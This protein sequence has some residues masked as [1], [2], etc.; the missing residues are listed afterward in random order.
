MNRRWASSVGALVVVIAASAS[1]VGAST[2]GAHQAHSLFWGSATSPALDQ[3]YAALT[4]V[5]AVSADDVWA[6]GYQVL[7]SRV[8]TLVEHWDGTSWSVVPSPNPDGA[9]E[10]FLSGVDAVATDNVWAVGEFHY[11]STRART[12][13]EH[14]NGTSWRRVPSPN[15]AGGRYGSLLTSVSAGA[16][17]SVWAV[18][19]VDPPGGD[20]AHTLALHWNGGSWSTVR[21][22][23]R[24]G[25]VRGFFGVSATP[26]STAWAVGTTIDR[27][28]GRLKSLVEHWNGQRWNQAPIVSPGRNYNELNAVSVVAPGNAWAV[29]V[30]AQGG[31][32]T[33]SLVERLTAGQW[34][35]LRPPGLGR[36]GEL[37]SVSGD[38]RDDV[39]MVG[40][41]GG[42]SVLE[43]WDGQNWTRFSG[44][45]A[46]TSALQGVTTHGSTATWAVGSQQSH[47]YY[48]LPFEI[49]W[50]GH[51]W[52]R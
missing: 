8:D 28:T 50:N 27:D 5:T 25:V 26:E 22:P 45:G 36:V 41:A 52:T 32:A 39:W 19:Y 21:T 4:G 29:G 17:D 20:E 7:R 6:V 23:F 3:G 14:W 42:A 9:R 31:S 16:A 48:A 13:V 24:Q 47:H 35:Q 43:H 18:G 44:P 40:R 30:Y 1:A 2:P 11:S 38:G 46:A 37:T 49:R 51:V 15:P 10:T 33:R 34:E 12:L